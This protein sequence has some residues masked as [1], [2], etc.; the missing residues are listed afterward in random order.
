MREKIISLT[1]DQIIG[2]DK[3]K[4]T[5]SQRQDCRMI[6]NFYGCER[7]TEEARKFEMKNKQEE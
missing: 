4:L 3:Y 2:I 5:P 6:A 1:L 7:A